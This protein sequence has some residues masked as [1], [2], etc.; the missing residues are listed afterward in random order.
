MA[1][2]FSEMTVGTVVSDAGEFVRFDQDLVGTH[3]EG[4]TLHVEYAGYSKP[5]AVNIKMKRVGGRS[6]IT[7]IEVID[8]GKSLESP[9]ATLTAKTVTVRGKTLWLGHTAPWIVLAASV[10]IVSMCLMLF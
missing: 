2:V 3:W 1:T 9:K 4:N 5:P 6:L 7:G 10:V 8:G